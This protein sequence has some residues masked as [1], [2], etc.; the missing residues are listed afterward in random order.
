MTPS[1][2]GRSS[3]R[4]SRSAPVTLGV[5]VLAVALWSVVP[6]SEPPSSELGHAWTALL[7]L[8]GFVVAELTLLHVEVRRH[9]VSLSLVEI[10]LVL[11]LFLVGPVWLLGARLL[12]ALAVEV[13]RRTALQKVVFNLA[14]YCAEVAAVV[15]VFRAAS[16]DDLSGPR[17]WLAAYVAATVGALLT[18]ALVCVVIVRVQG[19]LP[20]QDLVLL[21]APLV[22][23]ALLST[24]GALV[25]LVTVQADA[26]AGL[27][28]AALLLLSLGAYRG[29]S[30]LLSRHR[31]LN[32][33]RDFT[34]EM[35]AGGGADALASAALRH[36]RTLLSAGEAVLALDATGRRPSTARQ[37]REDGEHLVETCAHPV[38]DRVRAT[39]VGVV[40]PRG[41]RDPELAG[42]LADQGLHD[43]VMVP[44]VG[45][46]GAVGALQ[47]AQ[48]LGETGT[49]TD[50]DRQ[51][52]QMVAVHLEVALRSV[53]LVEDLRYEATHDALTG[54]PNRARFVEVVQHVVAQ[55][56]PQDE[57]AV[58]LLDLDGFKDINDTLGHSR[59]DTVL[60]EV[61]LRL[62]ELVPA[63]AVV[64]RLGGDEF[65]LLVPVRPE[66]GDVEVVVSLL[67]R[68]LRSPVDIDAMQLEVRASVGV[69]RWPDHG[70]EASLLL[71][72][73]DIALYA[74]KETGQ[75]FLV[76]EPD[77][78]RSTP[79]RLELVH[80]LRA[81]VEGGQ[82]VCHYQPKLT[83]DGATV[84]GAEALVRWVHPVLGEIGPDEFVPL[85][86]RTGLMA[87]LTSVVLGAALHDC[88]RWRRSGHDLGV[89]VNV[90]PRGLLAPHLARE[91]R[92]LLEASRVPPHALTLEITEGSVMSEPAK[93][94]AVLEELHALGLQLSIDDFGTGYS[95]LSYL[96][97]LPVQEVKIDKS[98]V[99]DLA[100]RSSNVAIVAAI[101]GL[102]R[103][104]RLRVVAEG[105]EDEAGLR[106]LQRLG[107]EAVQG[108]LFSRPLP[109]AAFDAWLA[110]R[111]AGSAAAGRPAS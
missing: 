31:S 48:R 46:D 79:R 90:S 84:L 41:T 35:S 42:W 59:G 17:T 44:L 98:F 107:C 104:L 65:A 101:V 38:A 49:F 66:P 62:V 33:M 77:L 89:A 93:A 80:Q 106:E 94:L 20:R 15:L 73:A 8:G 67:Q 55:R 14:L 76:Y 9:A 52:L 40:A 87:A 18:G 39:G 68:A 23:G 111:T 75:P 54:L 56:R 85:A 100:G 72:R 88:A 103:N 30:T 63:A 91:V 5:A 10:P 53:D 61:A 97:R 43:A 3:R 82:L 21:L 45:V 7:L 57:L 28:L 47:V 109:A 60:R 110:E 86:E 34:V 26:R 71:Q 1:P 64:A 78:D 24:T 12:A 36:A 13:Y 95:S 108:Y 4:P 11:G 16:G 32:Q 81:A 6:T 50:A 99:T 22:V 58:V 37:Q 27:L 2:S 96:H 29:Y 69:A 25:G 70:S 51:L 83:V 19:L 74:A 92:S 105:V 102:A